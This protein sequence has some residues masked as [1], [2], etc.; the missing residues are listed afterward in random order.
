MEWNIRGRN[1]LTLFMW[2]CAYGQEKIVQLLLD[3]HSAKKIQLYATETHYGLT[4]LQW[5]GQNG[6]D[7]VVKILLDYSIS[8]RIDWNAKDINGWN[9]FMWARQKGCKVIITGVTITMLSVILYK[10]HRYIK[11]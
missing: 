7:N 10:I 8:E 6:H 2:A 3:L 11:N 5:A 1:G 9:T 4:A